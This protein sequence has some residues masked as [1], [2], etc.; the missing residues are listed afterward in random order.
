[1]GCKEKLAW[2]LPAQCS[3][4]HI[5]LSFLSK[6]DHRDEQKHLPI[7][8]KNKE[9]ENLLSYISS[10][11]MQ[12]GRAVLPIACW[13]STHSVLSAHAHEKPFS[14]SVFTT[15][16]SVTNVLLTGETMESSS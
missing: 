8:C 13:V 16:C 4:R 12:G 14:P 11:C 2:N 10:V 9:T 5:T 6:G 1:M 3:A 15:N 7:S